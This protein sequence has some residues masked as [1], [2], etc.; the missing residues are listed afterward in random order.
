MLYTAALEGSG[1]AWEVLRQRMASGKDSGMK[2]NYERK[3][4]IWRNGKHRD[5]FGPHIAR[6]QRVE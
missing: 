4:N 6:T 1:V 3:A 2:M 5:S